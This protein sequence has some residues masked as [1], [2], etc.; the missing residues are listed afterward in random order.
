MNNAHGCKSL[1]MCDTDHGNS[2]QMFL[3][4]MKYNMLFGLFL[5][6]DGWSS[7]DSIIA[8]FKIC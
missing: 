2:G 4:F 1:T 5:N 3:L 8:C 6:R 7:H